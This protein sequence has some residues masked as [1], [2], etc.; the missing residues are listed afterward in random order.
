MTGHAPLSLLPAPVGS[1]SL[2]LDFDGTLVP[3]AEHPDAI[4]VP[5]G[6]IGLLERCAHRLDG[7]QLI[8]SGR[9]LADLDHHLDTS[10]LS[11][12]GS[13]GLE[14]RMA[15]AEEQLAVED[16]D[17][18]ALLAELE[19]YRAAKPGLEVERKRFGAALHF[20]QAPQLGDAAASFGHDLAERHGLAVKK[21]KMVVELGPPGYD[22]GVAVKAVMQQ[23]A[24]ANSVPL[25]IGD[26]V[27][28]EDGFQAARELGGTAIIVGERESE[29]AEHRLAE[30]RDVHALVTA[31][32]EAP[33]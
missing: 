9:T 6:L 20:R 23:R 8:I 12:C 10:A 17:L 5:M 21:G 1:L 16:F 29:S 13:H 25:Y 4:E 18:A 19:R 15:G 32:A 28:D 27:T 26:D 2:F 31:I 7:R 14:R 33:R 22:K 24:F 11:L 3:L 30:P